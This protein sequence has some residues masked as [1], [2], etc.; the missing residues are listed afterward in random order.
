MAHDEP[1]SRSMSVSASPQMTADTT[2]T[3][4]IHLMRA[5]YQEIPGLH[6][7]Q[8]QA[9]RLWG[10]HPTLCEALL[11]TLVEAKFLVRSPEGFYRRADQD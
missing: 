3:D 5:E 9:Q 1:V 4:W 10:L 6:L 2:V 7:T 11:H 8:A